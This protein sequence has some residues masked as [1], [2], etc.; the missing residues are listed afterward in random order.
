MGGASQ[1]CPHL[2]WLMLL[3]RPVTDAYPPKP[4]PATSV[5]T[6]MNQ[7][8]ANISLHPHALHTTTTTCS[9]ASKL[10]VCVNKKLL[11]CRHWRHTSHA[12]ALSWLT[13][14]RTQLLQGMTVL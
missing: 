9:T 13:G 8:A 3:T 6:I 1:R 11:Q 2:Y 10:V 4:S 5:D 7:L 12:T 14:S